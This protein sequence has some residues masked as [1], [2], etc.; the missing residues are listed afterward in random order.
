[1]LN[2]ENLEDLVGLQV[3]AVDSLATQMTLIKTYVLS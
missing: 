3:D 2:V 1:M